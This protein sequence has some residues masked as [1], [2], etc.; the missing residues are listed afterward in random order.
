[1]NETTNLF[2][3][4]GLIED[5]LN[6]SNCKQEEN[7][8]MNYLS[9]GERILSLARTKKQ[10]AVFKT[11]NLTVRLCDL[12]YPHLDMQDCKAK[13]QIQNTIEREI[14]KKLKEITTE[15]CL[16]SKGIPFL[17]RF[18]N[19]NYGCEMDSAS[20]LYEKRLSREVSRSHIIL[21][22]KIKETIFY[23]PCSPEKRFSNSNYY[24]KSNPK[25]HIHMYHAEKI[26]YPLFGISWLNRLKIDSFDDPDIL[27]TMKYLLRD[28]ASILENY[29]WN[30]SNLPKWFSDYLIDCGYQED[31][32]HN[33][34]TK[35]PDSE[36]RPVILY[37]EFS[38]S[39]FELFS[40]LSFVYGDSYLSYDILLKNSD[41]SAIIDLP[42][43]YREYLFMTLRHYI[44]NIHDLAEEEK[45]R[46]ELKR[47]VARA[48]QTK[49]KIPKHVV[50]EMK[51]SELNTYFGF[52]EFDEEV[53]LNLVDS[54]T[55]EF[56]KLNQNIF[57]GYISKNVALRFRK[58]GKHHATGLYYPSIDTMVVDFRHP[59][60]FVHEYFHMLDDMLGD[61][62]MKCEF[63]K[64]ALRY[65]QLLKSSIE[66]ERKA[67]KE[68]LLKKGKYNLNYFL[69]KC[70]IFARCGEIHLFRNLHVVSSL[71]KPEETHYFAY[72]DDEILN[73]MI[74]EYYTNLLNRIKIIGYKTGEDIYEKNLHIASV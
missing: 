4:L 56:K 37:E 50:H 2:I 25:H 1:M 38:S 70:E 12:K 57:N 7:D 66:K 35:T 22:I 31:T 68:M 61:P 51:A 58:L 34:Y 46:K 59:T 26:L 36:N 5:T 65:Q 17:L 20:N 62:S 71:L 52:I 6:E 41:K 49:K 47:I 55:E 32:I 44:T 9:E 53:D 21:I 54:I 72:P 33:Y 74:E 18:I 14:K 11:P 30:T 28:I 10:R 63:D 39:H 13:Q 64:V 60:S 8:C 16:H 67:G 24:Y 42:Y 23:I 73:N 27:D 40:L 43:Y 48:Y 3:M 15:E 29:K 45:H 19:K 69:R